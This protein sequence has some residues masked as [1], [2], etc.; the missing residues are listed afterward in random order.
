MATEDFVKIVVNIP[1]GDL[2]MYGEGLWSKPLGND[3]Y[4]VQNSPWHSR[5][6]NYLDFV[7]AVAPSQDKNPVFVSIEKRGGHRTIQIIVLDE[8]K[9]RKD[10]ILAK[11]NNL[12][13]TYENADGSLFALDFA[14]DVSW[15]PARTYLDDAEAK[16]WLE[17][18]WSAY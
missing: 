17:Y 12:G 5:E 18:R 7:K 13:A 3:L 1:E 10:E 8:G 15:D 11:L 14:P 2:G 4:E 6:I 9:G 16:S